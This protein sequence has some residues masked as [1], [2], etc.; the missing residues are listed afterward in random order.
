MEPETIGAKIKLI[1]RMFELT[2]RDM[3]KLTGVSN[4]YLSQLENS[5]AKQP[6]VEKLKLI[7]DGMGI[8]YHWLVGDLDYEML[9]EE[10]Q[11][12]REQLAALQ[13]PPV[14]GG[15]GSP[16]IRSKQPPQGDTE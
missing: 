4:A 9:V 16:I 10:N 6:S 14:D 15:P 12:L 11:R 3:E 2:L 8:S 13:R 1:R 7:A 5:R